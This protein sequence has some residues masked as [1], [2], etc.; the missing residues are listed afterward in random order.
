MEKIRLFVGAGT[1]IAVGLAAPLLP[2]G[3]SSSHDPDGSH[4]TNC[5][6]GTDCDGG[7]TCDPSVLARFDALSGAA[8][9]LVT[10]AGELKAEVATA[11]ANIANDLGQQGVPAVTGASTS[12]DDLQTACDLATA[13]INAAINAGASF[14]LMI[15]GGEC[16]VDAAAQISCEAACRVDASCDL[17]SVETRCAPGDLAGSCPGQCAG[18]CEV[19]SGAVECLGTCRAECVGTCSGTC[20]GGCSGNCTGACDGQSSTGPCG[21]TCAGQCDATCSGKCGAECDGTC[22]GSC[23]YSAPSAT[24]EGRCTGACDVSFTAPTCGGEL[25]PPT[26]EVD[27]DCE[28]G[29]NGSALYS[30]VCTPP[31]VQLVFSGTPSAVLQ[32]TLEVNLP[33]IIDGYQ[34]KGA[35]VFQAAAGIATMFGGA[36]E[37]ALSSAAC[38]A[39]L[40]GDVAAQ[41]SAVV[42]AAAS[43]SVSFS[44]SASVGGAAGVD[45]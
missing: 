18:S 16:I 2:S 5:D 12:D 15:S 4:P 32:A 41:A 6:A 1:V 31:G 19:Q 7:L 37:A 8:A 3:C 25:T 21:G 44:A 33:A 27:A 45:Q 36:V 26:C 35:L 28:A 10:A 11:C 29:C 34:L 17:G 13:A 24:C 9:A 14:E 20:T 22:S 38:A 23:Q 30:A 42:A 40:S 43:V 39:L